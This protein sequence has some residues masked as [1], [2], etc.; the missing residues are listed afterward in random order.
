[1]ALSVLGLTSALLSS[2]EK[3]DKP[4][5]AISKFWKAI[6]DYFASNAEVNYSW[7]AALS[8]PPNTKDPMLSFVGTIKTGGSLNLSNQTTPS[9]A[10]NAMSAQMN[11]AAALWVVTPPVGFSLSP[12]FII[13]S[14]KLSLSN[15]VDRNTAMKSIATDII[16]GIKLAT[17]S[18]AGLHASFV[19]AGT[20]IN[21][22]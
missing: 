17:Q 19:G 5:E 16:N 7:N 21:I 2:T 18:T 8:S 12:M 9:G 10:L 1:M 3:I 22:K 14:I 13:P 11:S 6:C 20:F 15:A 4:S